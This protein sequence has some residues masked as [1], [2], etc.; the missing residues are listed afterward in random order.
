MS[1]DAA[2]IGYPAARSYAAAKQRSEQSDV[3]LLPDP[4][5][6]AAVA[7]LLGTAPDQLGFSVEHPDYAGVRAVA[8]PAFL[9]G[10]AV[11]VAP[12]LGGLA[13]LSQS[14]RT[15]RNLARA[16]G[17]R[18]SSPLAVAREEIGRSLPSARGS[19]LA[20][21]VSPR[22]MAGPV[23]AGSGASV[24]PSRK[25]R[26]SFAPESKQA[27]FHT[28]S[29]DAG[30]YYSLHPGDVQAVLGR[31]RNSAGVVHLDA[32]GQLTPY[33]ELINDLGRAVEAPSNWSYARPEDYRAAMRE[34]GVYT[35]SVPEELY[36][37]E[38][39]G[40][41]G[42]PEDGLLRGAPAKRHIDYGPDRSVY[43]ILPLPEMR[44]A[45]EYA[46]Y[47]ILEADAPFRVYHG[48]PKPWVG[49]DFKPKPINPKQRYLGD[50]LGPHATLDQ[51][52][53]TRFS[54]GTNAESELLEYPRP[55]A[56][57]RAYN[58]RRIIEVPH[59][60]YGVDYDDLNSVIARLAGESSETIISTSPQALNT[61]I[62]RA[63][64]N[65]RR[66]GI[67]ALRY[68]NTGVE[69][70][71]LPE[72]SPWV[73]ESTSERSFLVL[74]HVKSGYAR[75]GLTRLKECSCGR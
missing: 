67:D 43:K 73:D 21:V 41:L 54:Y 52:L 2:Y 24:L 47:D 33:D 42:V 31:G 38:P 62:L 74:P 71:V 51:Y 69:L 50:V 23:R 36:S 22:G 49:D 32:A 72:Y 9:A 7:S 44:K 15:G 63:R 30:G 1:E 10:T 28:H 48:T 64:E 14:L 59:E 66:H 37:R 18:E 40:D 6:Y 60:P 53:A 56:N 8:G 16:V 4:R 27:D 12:V 19:E 70:E 58:P 61:W 55:G 25:S 57:V 75:G 20:V 26:L 46:G 17:L 29:A 45:G 11:G 68:K 3:N 5:T 34:R 65:A 13:R 39:W 35:S